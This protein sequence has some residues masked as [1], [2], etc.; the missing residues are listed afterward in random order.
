MTA[1]KLCLLFLAFMS[2]G[3]GACASGFQAVYD[4]DRSHDFSDHESWA[5]ISDHPMTV[6]ELASMPNPLLEP[7][8]MQAIE[9]NLAAKGFTQVDDPSSADFAVAF[10]VGS[11]EKIRVDSYPSYYGGYGY[12][13]RWGG[14]YYGVGYGVDT[15]VREYTQGT[16]AVDVFDVAEQ[17]PV[18]HG[19]AE[20][21]I[22]SSD[23]KNIEET[24]EAAVSAVLGGFPPGAD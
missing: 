16:I 15:Q 11:R 23:R 6:G 20:K 9:R 24:I 1:R 19:V 14:A 5:W 3:L 13:G 4:Y 2:L 21:S 7:R 8:I 10:T 12:P 22:T 18:W 17:I